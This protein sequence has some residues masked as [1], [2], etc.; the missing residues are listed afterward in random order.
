L[1]GV[2][3]SIILFI[4]VF[5]LAVLWQMWDV[6][7]T[8]SVNE[9]RSPD[10][11]LLLE[12]EGPPTASPVLFAAETPPVVRS[13]NGTITQIEGTTITLQ[14]LSGDLYPVDV[15]AADVTRKKIRVA[16]P[17][18]KYGEGVEVKSTASPADFAIRQHVVVQTEQEITRG[19]TVLASSVT[20]LE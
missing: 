12:N 16:S 7:K 1:P 15:T 3:L 9:S 8:A 14:T 6:A 11:S 19:Q 18:L 13:L 20:I 5:G 4:L 2:V 17:V 10:A